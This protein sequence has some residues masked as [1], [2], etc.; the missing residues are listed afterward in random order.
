MSINVY[1]IATP[2][3]I[4]LAMGE[5]IYCVAKRNGYY[6][7]QDSIASVGT[8][9]INQCV[10]VAV[11]LLVL[12]LFAQLGQFAFWK[13]DSTSPWAILGLFL[14]VDFLFYWFHRFGHRTNI[15]WAAHSPHH[16]TE[17]LNYAVALRASVTQRIFSFLFYWPLVIVGFSPEAVLTMVA[18]H[19]VLQFIPHTRVIPKM[20][21]WIES[22]LNTPS[23][24]RVHHARNERYLDKNY[25]GSLIIWDRMFGTYAEETE[26]CSYGVTTPPN[27]WDPTFINFQYWGKLVSDAVK[28][29]STWDRLRLWLMPTGWRPSDLPPRDELKWTPGEEAK[30]QSMEL[31]NIRGYLIFQMVTSMPFMLLVSHH[32]SPLTGWQKLTLSILFWAMATAWG[33]MM[34]SKRWGL[35]LE[36]ARVLT[37]GGS[38]LLWL[39]QAGAPLT[40]RTLTA[41]WLAV[42]L[43]W[44]SVA[45]MSHRTSA[46]E[47]RASR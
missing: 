44:L 18:F 34:E 20:P 28:T 14:G 22:W 3:V 4:A 42:T 29:R 6:S 1:A 24:H 35:P 37:S 7:F 31:P 40:W 33:G 13:F 38:V 39:T 26:E 2:F 12:P 17:E 36:M 23:H 43:V 25:A 19:L 8:A 27:T 10:N 15:G 21:R 11:A 45:R 5:F 41:A 46:P 16:S 30:F 9:V 47:P 32:G